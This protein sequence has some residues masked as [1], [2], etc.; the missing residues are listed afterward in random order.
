MNDQYKVTK[1]YE[2]PP[3]S[4]P[5]NYIVTKTDLEYRGFTLS[6]EQTNLLWQVEKAP[7]GIPEIPH[8][9]I[10]KYTSLSILQK[11]VDDYLENVQKS[12]SFPPVQDEC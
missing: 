3:P 4:Y 8:K 11:A 1:T 2:A 10:G 5:P 9:L 6:R 12:S 7:P